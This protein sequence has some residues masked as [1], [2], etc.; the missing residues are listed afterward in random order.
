MGFWGF[1]PYWALPGKSV[2]STVI[3]TARAEG[4]AEAGTTGGGGGGDLHPSPKNPACGAWMPGS[5]RCMGLLATGQGGR[6]P[7]PM[8]L[9]RGSDAPP[10]HSHHLGSLTSAP[11][12]G[13]RPHHGAPRVQLAG[14]RPAQRSGSLDVQL[15]PPP[16]GTLGVPGVPAQRLSTPPLV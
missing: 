7:P 15:C 9:D 8:D 2:V 13:P 6:R 16:A 11:R 5:S 12:P 14:L 1:E 10:E 3:M 4:A